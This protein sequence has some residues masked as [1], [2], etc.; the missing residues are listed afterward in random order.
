ME[1]GVTGCGVKAEENQQSSDGGREDQYCAAMC[2][3]VSC[4]SLLLPF[5]AVLS[6]E[7]QPVAQQRRSL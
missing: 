6:D 2:R 4:V 5:A 7:L 3:P 1:S